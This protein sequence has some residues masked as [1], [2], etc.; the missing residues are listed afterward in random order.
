M[1][2]LKLPE[3]M[4]DTIV[5]VLSDELDKTM[6]ILHDVGVMHVTKAKE[7]SPIDKKFIEERLHRVEVLRNYLDR[8]LSFLPEP[9]LVEV[10]ETID[11]Y[12]LENILNEVY[13][14]VS[15]IRNE[16]ENIVHTLVEIDEQ[17]NTL[18]NRLRYIK[19]LLDE[20]GDVK[21]DLLNY[22][23]KLFLIKTIVL[24]K[25]VYKQFIEKVKEIGIVLGTIVYE[26]EVIVTISSPT[27]IKDRL[28]SIIEEYRGIVLDFLKNDTLGS[29]YKSFAI[30]I[31]ELSSKKSELQLK[32][33]EIVEY[34]LSDIALAK[35]VVDN[36]YMRLNAIVSGAKSKFIVVIR[37][38]VPESGKD[39]LLKRLYEE[40]HSAVVN[41][42]KI[43]RSLIKSDEESEE[44]PPSKLVNRGVNKFFELLTKLYGLPNYNEWD[45]T[46]L[47]TLFFPVFFGFMIGDAVYGV[48]LIFL[49]KFVL[50]KL[51]DNPESEGYKL[52]KGMLY[53]SAI[54]TIIAGTLQASYMGDLGRYLL[55]IGR[56]EYAVIRERLTPIPWLISEQMFIVFALLIGLVHVNL[57]H[58][59]ALIKAV[60][61]RATWD[62]LNELGI[63]IAE[64]FGLPYILSEMLGIIKIPYANV[65][66]YLAFIGI[67]MVIVSKVK[68]MGMFGGI[69]WL[70][71]LT[72]L[73]GDVMSYARIAGVGLATFYLAMSFNQISALIYGGITSMIN[74]FPGIVLGIIL[75][76]PVFLIGHLLNIALSALGAFVH[77]LRLFYVEFL[78]KFYSGNGIEFKPLRIVFQRRI[79]LTPG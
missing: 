58:L 21:V 42:V 34:N 52:F 15:K 11:A 47:I 8:I 68:T 36:E 25:S 38:W 32:L 76:I 75:S 73:L 65:L 17:Y 23:G 64:V 20:Y 5:Y 59:L 51:V 50:D 69:L 3:D 62:L 27:R 18:T 37:G 1:P 67:L 12:R 41:M 24:S 72:G 10:K 39:M 46:P 19:A 56:E 70:F 16:I 57:A 79:L 48:I 7:L 63:F 13:E 9:K 78:P 66:V 4:Y 14:R 2:L 29:L 40:T 77:S 54:A 26:N 49:T 33:R 53:V 35:L 45:P 61:F 31:N 22:E 55:G 30:K 43:K 74:G 44:E 28:L 60:K 71:D 6:T